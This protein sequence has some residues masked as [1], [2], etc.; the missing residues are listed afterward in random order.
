MYRF[1]Q[2]YLL[3]KLKLFSLIVLALVFLC[4]SIITPPA[5]AAQNGETYPWSSTTDMPVMRQQLTALIYNGWIY[6]VGGDD[7]VTVSGTSN[8]Y[9]APVN[10]DGSI[11]A[12]VLNAGAFPACRHRHSSAIVKGYLFVIGGN[13]A[14]SAQ[15][16][17]YRAPINGD[18]SIGTFTTTTSLPSGRRRHSTWVVNDYIFVA[19]GSNPGFDTVYSAHIEDNGNVLSW[20]T[21]PNLLPAKRYSHSSV[22]YNNYAY[23][24]GGVDETAAFVNSVYYAQVNTDGTTDA[25]QTNAFSLPENIKSHSSFVANGYVYVVGGQLESGEVLSTV[26]FAKLNSDGSTGEWQLSAQTLPAVRTFQAMTTSANFAYL[27]GGD[28]DVLV[29]GSATSVYKLSLTALVNFDTVSVGDGMVGSSYNAQVT[30][31]DGVNPYSFAVSSGTLPPGI[32]LASSTGALSGTPT[33][34]GSYEFTITI[35][36]TDAGT[37]SQTFN[38]TILPIPPAVTPATPVST[39][40]T[41]PRSSAVATPIV[42]AEVIELLNNAQSYFE[43]TGYELSMVPSEIKEFCIRQEASCETADKHSVTLNEVGADYVVLTYASTPQIKRIATGETV[44]VD[45]NQ[46]G[47]A[48]IQT[49]LLSINEGAAVLN[50]AYL[51]AT[52]SPVIAPSEPVK[53]EPT[54]KVTKKASRNY[55][56]AAIPLPIIGVVIFLLAKRFRKK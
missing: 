23:I 50:F 18:G 26:Y 48:D 8:V 47:T 24:I 31:A 32:S 51:A 3:R 44:Q 15:A 43:Q 40:K 35:T 34:Q 28:D 56:Y 12:W 27:V 39:P 9:R 38:V 55:W 20:A 11:G 5:D 21:S 7:G 10:S 54:I 16:G 46:D 4:T 37:S 29:S 1:S 2:T 52:Q 33:T 14:G 22:L 49:K 17:V 6:A 36:D 41:T 42:E 25:W 13:C 30:A 45:V 53:T 19:G